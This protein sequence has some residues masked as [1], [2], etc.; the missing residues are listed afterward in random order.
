MSKPSPDDR[1]YSREHEWAKDNGDGTITMGITDYAQEM[2]TDVV[3]VELPETGKKVKQMQVV[4][5]VESVKSVSDVYSPVSGE[6]TEVNRILE[7]RPEIVN[8]DAFGEGWLCRIR[9]DD[10]K[11]LDSLMSSSRYEEFIKDLKH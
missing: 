5:V 1:R 7:E 4:A 3:F 2:L 10:P 9:M 8:Q 11:E 6:V